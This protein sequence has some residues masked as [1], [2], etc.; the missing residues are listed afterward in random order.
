[1]ESELIVQRPSW[2]VKTIDTQKSTPTAI[3]EYLRRISALAR[4]AAESE[5][6][7]VTKRGLQVL[8]LNAAYLNSLIGMC[9]ESR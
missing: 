5:D 3:R 2:R 8:A 4:E 7:A 1:M 9:G 6:P